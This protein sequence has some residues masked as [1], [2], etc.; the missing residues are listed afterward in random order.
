MTISDHE[1]KVLLDAYAILEERAGQ[2]AVW[3]VAASAVEIVLEQEELREE[4]VV[5]PF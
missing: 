4:A 3:N 2:G 5:A 1:R